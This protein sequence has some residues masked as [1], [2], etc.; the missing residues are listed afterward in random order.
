[1]D[2]KDD[3]SELI[4]K[5]V[6]VKETIRSKHDIKIVNGNSSQKSESANTSSN[7]KKFNNNV[8]Y[9]MKYDSLFGG[10]TS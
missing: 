7:I 9:Y 6:P 10:I 1:M 4:V 5:D 8:I 2:I 3:Q